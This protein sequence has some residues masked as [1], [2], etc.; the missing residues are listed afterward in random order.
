MAS[1][2][3]LYAR[4]VQLEHTLFALPFSLGSM[5]LA[6][7]GLPTLSTF[8]W[9]LLALV[10]GRSFAMAM[11][12][13]ADRHLDPLNP[14]TRDRVLPGRELG[15]GEVRLFLAVSAAL[16]V[17]AA[18]QLPSLCLKLLP[19]ALAF[20]TLYSYAKR[21]TWTAHFI[22][23]FCLAMA[24]S[25]SW[26]AVRGTLDAPAATLGLAI[27]LWVSGFDIL[28]A[29]QDIEFDRQRDL[30]SIPA[31]FGLE[32]SQTL[33]RALHAASCAVIWATGLLLDASWIYHAGAAV[34][35][36]LV[37]YEHRVVRGG[38]LTRI[39]RAFFEVNALV[40]ATF[41]LTAALE[42]LRGP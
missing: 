17:L 42:V 24:V 31:R 1:K 5:L 35:A 14:R 6:A 38:D 9:I 41:L 18:S 7:K 26:I 4:M 12:R 8:L 32:A 15:L 29:G 37:A 40:S 21:F 13:Y 27:V 22:L 39:Q 23:G 3:T 20:L 36:C 30:K 28:Y 25:G 11:N 10:S 19:V 34:M 2:L 33:A 16:L